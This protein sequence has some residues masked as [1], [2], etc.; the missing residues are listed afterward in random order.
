MLKLV[1]DFT[2]G[3]HDREWLLR[4]AFALRG[5]SRRRLARLRA[6]AAVEVNRMV[7]EREE[8]RR[9]YEADKAQQGS[10][11]RPAAAIDAC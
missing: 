11:L 2:K 9:Q 1:K 6:A 8:R 10:P 5:L 4:Q 7:R 3:L